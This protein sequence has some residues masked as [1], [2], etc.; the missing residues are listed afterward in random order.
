MRTSIPPRPY[1]P[2]RSK[3]FLRVFLAANVSAAVLIYLKAVRDPPA[4]AQAEA[5][6]AAAAAAE[7][8]STPPPQASPPTA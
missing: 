3:F 6:R 4:R 8:A 1:N 7:R 5:S 2:F